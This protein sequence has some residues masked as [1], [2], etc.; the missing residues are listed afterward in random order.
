MSYNGLQARHL[1][2]VRCGEQIINHTRQAAYQ[3]GESSQCYPHRSSSSFLNA[4]WA[5]GYLF[6]SLP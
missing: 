5:W 6:F 4:S 1:F 3:E 2:A